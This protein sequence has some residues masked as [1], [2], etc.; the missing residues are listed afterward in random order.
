LQRALFIFVKDGAKNLFKNL[1]ID[2][3][4]SIQIEIGLGKGADYGSPFTA[5]FEETLLEK[6]LPILQKDYQ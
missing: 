3:L 5:F 4:G 6:I 2:L 1:N